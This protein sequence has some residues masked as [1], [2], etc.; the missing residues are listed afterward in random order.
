MKYLFL[1]FF[2][3]PLFLFAQE[4][5]KCK[6]INAVRINE[7]I[8]LDGELNEPAWLNASTANGFYT[9]DPV[10]GNPATEKTEVKFLFDDDAI[11]IGAMMYDSDPSK[12][13]K[14]FTKRDGTNPN[15][16]LF[17]FT[18][19]PNED[20]Q[21]YFQFQ[22]SSVN[23]Q[24]DIKGSSTGSDI[25][26]NAVWFSET[27]ISEKGWC[28]EIKIPYSALRFPNKKEQNWDVNF[29]RLIRRHRESSSWNF[30]DKKLG[31]NDAQSGKITGIDNIVS[32]LR[33][34]FYPYIS[35]YM[36]H[37][38][39][40]KKFSYAFNGGMDVK[41]GLT[42]S[43]T[44]DVTLIPD[45]GQT[46][47]DDK[48]LNLTPYETKYSENRQFFTEGIDLFNK[49]GL[50]Y[51]RRIGRTPSGFYDM[52]TITENKGKIIE[53]PSESKLINATKISGRNK[54]NLG[55]GFFNAVVNNTYAVVEDSLGNRKRIVTEPF[56]NY[57]IIVAEKT[58]NKTSYVNIINTNVFSPNNKTI[59]DVSGISFRV[60]EPKNIYAIQGFSALSMKKKN[61]TTAIE[62]GRYHNLNIGKLNGNLYF[63][64]SI[65]VMTDKYD[66]NDMGYLA[67][68]NDFSQNATVSYR[69]WKPFWRM[70][71]CSGTLAYNFQ[72]LYAP[73]VFSQTNFN[74]NL[75]TTFKNYFS[76]GLYNSIE[77]RGR[78]DYYEPRTTGRFFNKSRYTSSSL[79]ASTDYRK[80]FALD[81][82]ADAFFSDGPNEGLFFSI[83]PR[84]RV[85]DHLLFTYA[86]N[87]GK[88]INDRGFAKKINADSIVFGRRNIQ[89]IINSFNGAYVFKNK[90]TLSL[91]LRHYWSKVDYREYYLLNDEGN[92]DA[93][94][95]YSENHDINFNTFTIDM[96]YSWNFAP[97]S[98]MNIMWKNDIYKEENILENK[99]DS[100]F[101]NFDKTINSSQINSLSVK[102][103]Y[104]IDYHTTHKKIKN[105]KTS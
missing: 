61:D 20:G 13:L 81:V 46:K 89:T 40:D 88:D 80:T 68:N 90:S 74:V 77:P 73:R 99:F 53:N 10:N 6:Q 55:L 103:I 71:S 52:D 39:A 22:V 26:W 45:F 72:K 18:I 59:A 60:Y 105:K 57:N 19:N 30:I 3:L 31:N 98:Y 91:T 7:S 85:N 48:V 37:N 79:W 100:F 65:S 104:Y 35:G 56:T 42:E 28:A 41:Y 63:N 87:P 11:Y 75:N 16:D 8:T 36:Q 102:L 69:I 82:T 70:L 54:N 12:I 92:L 33:L 101:P 38:S 83:S 95:G 14:E 29:W 50:F 93:Y 17:W 23:V 2:I 5:E 86:I 44:L 78:H 21:N 49:G 96:I 84:V 97:G 32:P 62:A 64:Y 76:I 47:S 43:F 34:E 27:K 15:A 24:T 67:R 94:L 66:P 58:F 1:Y 4:K 25:G 9:Y 51:S